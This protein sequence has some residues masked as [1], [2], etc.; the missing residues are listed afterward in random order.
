MHPADDVGQLF[1]SLVIIFLN[2]VG[3]LIRSG[4]DQFYTAIGMKAQGIDCRWISGVRSGD[5]KRVA[6]F[7][8]GKNFLLVYN[9]MGKSGQRPRFWF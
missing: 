2:G 9:I 7:V 5:N 1:F 3:D 4:N 8:N 6:V